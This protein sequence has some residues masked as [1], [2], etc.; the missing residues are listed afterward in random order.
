MRNANYFAK[1]AML[2]TLTDM[3]YSFRVHLDPKDKFPT[4]TTPIAYL[5]SYPTDPLA[6]T[7]KLCY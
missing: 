4:L 2:G 3:A 7:P 6:P 5:S 1:N